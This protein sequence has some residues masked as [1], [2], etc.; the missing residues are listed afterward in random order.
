ML[1]NEEI[2]C[3][4]LAGGK[5]SRL[6]GKGKYSQILCKKT[7]LEH[8]FARLSSQTSKIAVNLHNSKSNINLNFPL[9]LD[10]FKDDI[11]P[12]AGIHA[13]MAYCIESCIESQLVITVP[14][15][16]PFLPLDLIIK[17]KKKIKSSTADVVVACSGNRRHPTVAMWRI[18]LIEK[19]EY[20]I[21]NNI[22]KID[23]FTKELEKSY[24]SWDIH[25][26]DP[27]YNINNY[28][29]LKIAENMINKD[30]II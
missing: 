27:F 28:N 25:E 7:L 26:Y 13:S 8:V 22:R 21:K 29:D 17:F 12:L 18:S 30:I 4:I 5:G 15:D 2:Q 19:L 9:V 24:V 11:G 10:K 20:C 1:K 6:D 3:V 23:M 14:V 16:T